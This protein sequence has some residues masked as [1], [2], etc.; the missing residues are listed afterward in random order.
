MKL[1]WK[2]WLLH[3]LTSTLKR[4]SV[5]SSNVR[6]P[7][8]TATYTPELTIP[9]SPGFKVLSEAERTAALYNLLQRSTLFQ[10]QFFINVLQEMARD[11][12]MAT[13]PEL[14]VGSQH[15]NPHVPGASMQAQVD[16]K[17]ASLNLKSG[18]GIPA[19]PATRALN[20]QSLAPADPPSLLTPHSAAPAAKVKASPNTAHPVSGSVLSASTTGTWTGRLTQVQESNSLAA[21]D[22]PNGH[23]KSSDFAGS[24]CLPS[25]THSP[26]GSQTVIN[27]KNTWASTV[28][29]P[30]QSPRFR[31]YANRIAEL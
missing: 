22:S 25:A 21:A 16:E 15:S 30:L 18:N 31:R 8:L 3:L 12:P 14:S 27:N 29:P 4:N 20:S 19:S 1:L 6:I 23:P 10:I 13:L 2:K 9:S 28:N 7:Y 26:G 17:L 24:P 5:P 11:N